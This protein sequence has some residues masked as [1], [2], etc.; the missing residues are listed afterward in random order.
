MIKRHGIIPA[1]E[2]AVNRTD[3]S[4]GFTALVTMGMEDLAFEAI[5]IRHRELF[6]SETVERGRTLLQK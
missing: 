1:I 6:S 4:A 2:R 3:D 5:V